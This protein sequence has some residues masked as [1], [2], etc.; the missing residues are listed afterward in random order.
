MQPPEPT[1]DEDERLAALHNLSLLDT[2]PEERFD[3]ITRLARSHFGV[4]ICLV[5]LIDETRQWFKSRCGLDSEQTPREVSF[6]GH[7][8]HGDDLFE[9]SDATADPRFADN[10]L[11]TG[12]PYVRFYAGVPLSTADGY[13]IGTLCLIDKR[14]RHLYPRER[15]HLRDYAAMVEQEINDLRGERLRHEL[16]ASQRRSHALLGAFPDMVFVIS[17]SGT[18]IDCLHHED[19]LRPREEVLGRH[20]GEILPTALANRMCSHL[21]EA[22]RTGAETRFE[23]ELPFP[24]G[25]RAFEARLCP[26]DDEEVLVIARNATL[27]RERAAEHQRLAEVARQTTNGVMITDAQGRVEWLNE[28]FTRITGYTL[29]EMRGKV[30]GQIL[31]GPDTDPAVVVQMREALRE[32][33]AF[34]VELINYT[35]EARPYWIRISCSPLRDAAGTLQGYIAIETDITHEKEAEERLGRSGQLLSAVADANRIGIWQ[36]NV[37]TDAFEVNDTWIE[38]VG[39]TCAELGEITFQT[40][41]RLTHPDDLAHC[42]QCL[43]RH[44]S[45]E[46]DYYDEDIRMR[47]KA[48]HWVWI[49]TRGNLVSRLENGAP[50]LMLGTHIDITERRELEQRLAAEQRLLSQILKTNVSAITVLDEHGTIVFANDAASRILSPDRSPVVGRSYACDR[51]RITD[52]EGRVLS[53]EDLPHAQLLRADKA[54]RDFRHVMEFPDGERVILSVNGTRLES[55]DEEGLR[56]VLS[57]SDITT[58]VS[59]KRALSDRSKQ[60]RAVVDNILDAIVTID[61]YGHIESFNPAAERIFAY[62]ASEVLGKNVS[63][64]MPE[65]HRSHHDEYIA[66]YLKTH[67]AKVIGASRELEGR[68]SNGN[69]FPMELRISEY[70]RDGMIYFVGM[71]RDITKRRAAEAQINQL[72]FYDALTGLPNRRLL[73]DRLGQVIA[74]IRRRHAHAA[75][76]FIDLDNFKM[77]NDSAGHDKGDELL[78]QIA[79][80]L[81]ECVRGG[82]TVARIGGDEF[83]VLVHDLSLEPADAIHQAE[84]VAEKV[85]RALTRPFLL[86]G[87]EHYSSG[88]IGVTL[89]DETADSLELILKQADLA[90]YEAKTSGDNTIRFFDP[91]MQIAVEERAKL[92]SDLRRAMRNRELLPYFQLQVDARGEPVGAEILLRW[93]HPDRGLISP[94]T[95]IP[96]AEKTGLIVPIGLEVF[97]AACSCLARWRKHARTAQLTL[98]VNVSVVQFRNDALIERLAQILEQSGVE[99]SRLK[100]EITESVLA[101]DLADVAD[102]LRQLKALGLKLSLDDFGTGYSSLSYLKNLPLDQ[103]KIDQSFVRDLLDNPNDVAIAHSVISLASAIGLDVIAE[104]VETESQREM[105]ERIGCEY[106]QGYLFGWPVPLAEFENALRK[107]EKQ[108]D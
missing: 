80:R 89:I 55:G 49:N 30:P 94:A 37:T 14:P 77:L 27:E 85:Q 87:V 28:S 67:Q 106:F 103:I 93:E 48:G 88:S 21:N 58:E 70:M 5:S 62:S 69:I 73:I 74:A 72:A 84:F 90:M 104:G 45:G 16:A 36:W 3:R 96:L 76:L 42:Q 102:K 60:M 31:Q 20:L 71:M 68:R 40:W 105:L 23:Y 15:E 38:L 51:C 44:F 59:T 43:H 50:G 17:R 64:L 11:V 22:F 9:V 33:R 82:D 19:L 39:Y 61:A 107:R 1:D 2:S 18:F 13:K 66:N 57:I 81:S 8:I 12:P 98:S 10:P 99:P 83:V 56:F 52:L 24:E 34:D 53:P 95:F 35:H 86:E 79:Q 25:V 47:H 46:L 41:E 32:Q 92:E 91:Q 101:D 29:D 54:I 6:C 108:I 78:K 75:L 65:P 26:L 4:S 97:E 100:L 63:M 7:A